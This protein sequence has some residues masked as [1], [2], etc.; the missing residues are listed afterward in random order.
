MIIKQNNKDG[1]AVIIFDENEKNIIKENGELF[2][3]EVS[4]KHLTNELMNVLV[5]FQTN[6]KGGVKK[7][8]TYDDT[9]IEGKKNKDV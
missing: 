8:M 6:F 2:F 3:D 1:S 4:F 7:L 5:S 9:T